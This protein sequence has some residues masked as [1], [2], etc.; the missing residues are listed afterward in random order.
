MFGTGNMT[1]GV[2]GISTKEG[3][4]E[5]IAMYKGDVE[6]LARYLDW[7]EKKSGQDMFDTF[8]PDKATEH[9]LRVPVYDSTLLTFVKEVQKTKFINKNYV[10]TYSRKHMQTPQD[11]IRVIRETQIMELEVLGDILSKYVLKGMT[12]A[13]MWTDAIR[14]G[15]FYETVKRMKELIEFWTVPM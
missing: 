8:S 7:L 12:K 13:T 10:Y 6:M 2:S 11:E 5:K 4:A 1:G 3:V 15:V 14:T 9:T